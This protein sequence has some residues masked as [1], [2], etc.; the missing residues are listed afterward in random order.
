MA[1][2]LG[3]LAGVPAAFAPNIRPSLTAV[4]APGKIE[5]DGSL[6]DAGWAKDGLCSILY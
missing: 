4:R 1:D 3:G 5:V 2:P 6:D